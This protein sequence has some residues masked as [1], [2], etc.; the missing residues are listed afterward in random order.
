[1]AHWLCCV[2]SRAVTWQCGSSYLPIHYPQENTGEQEYHIHKNRPTPITCED[3]KCFLV[4]LFLNWYILMWKE[5]LWI[6]CVLYL[7]ISMIL[8]TST[9]RH[10]SVSIW[11]FVNYDRTSPTPGPDDHL[12]AIRGYRKM[13]MIFDNMMMMTIWCSLLLPMVISQGNLKFNW[14]MMP[15]LRNMKRNNSL[16]PRPYLEYFLSR[17]FLS[18]GGTW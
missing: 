7:C 8:R 10:L 9:T 16:V 6:W 1:M 2:S 18:E 15:L 5:L 3:S 4:K 14:S 17:K 13:N 11:A 12:F